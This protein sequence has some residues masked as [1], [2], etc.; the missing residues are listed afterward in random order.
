MKDHDGYHYL[1]HP[2]RGVH[3]VKHESQWVLWMP[4]PGHYHPDHDWVISKH[5]WA[6]SF[7][8]GDLFYS[9]RNQLLAQETAE[10]FG[11]EIET[12]WCA[13]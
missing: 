11:I 10:H 8:M 12:C 6:E 1:S 9:C 4:I 3:I 7:P 13:K 5:E 2:T